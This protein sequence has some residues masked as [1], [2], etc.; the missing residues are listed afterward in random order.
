MDVDKGEQEFADFDGA[1]K[2]ARAKGYH[3]A[4]SNDCFELWFFFTL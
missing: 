3:I 1:I 4:Y 2:S